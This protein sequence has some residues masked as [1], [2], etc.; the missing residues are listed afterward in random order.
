MNRRSAKRGLA[1]GLGLFCAG[2]ALPLVEVMV[3]FIDDHRQAYGASRR[4]ILLSQMPLYMVSWRRSSA[5]WRGPGERMPPM[6]RGRALT[7][8]VPAGIS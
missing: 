5:A 8:R 4:L 6:V 2:G 3:A 1:Q 7:Y